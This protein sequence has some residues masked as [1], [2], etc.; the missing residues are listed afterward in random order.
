MP[1]QNNGDDQALALLEKTNL[2]SFKAVPTALAPFESSTLSW[3]V[4]APTGVRIVLDGA[5]VNKSGQQVVEPPVTHA[6]NL[7]ARA[8]TATKPLGYVVVSVNLAQ[9]RILD[10]DFLDA[11]IQAG[12]LSQSSLLPSG[13]RFR[14]NPTVTI[15]PGLIQIVIKVAQNI[16][17]S[18]SPS[19]SFDADADITVSFGLTL[20]PDTRGH[21]GLGLP[22]QVATR[23][24]SVG[25]THSVDVSVPW[26]LWLIPGA[27]IGIPIAESMAEGSIDKTVP[28]MVQAIVDGLDA[29][30]H[31]PFAG[32]VKHSLKIDRTDN[33]I[34][35][36]ETTWCPTPQPILT[37]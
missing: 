12:I 23:F 7:S 17:I 11:W 24:A 14:E 34:A 27:M 2:V 37:A 35:F 20:V 19:L 36:L 3:D 10:L 21:F 28:P 15:T 6:Y 1:L 30:V 18:Q 16:V 22:G 5:T 4:N 32:L 13:A 31:P 8:G 9:C 25:E 33:N 26:Y 29:A